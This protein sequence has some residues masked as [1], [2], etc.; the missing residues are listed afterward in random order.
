MENSINNRK[1]RSKP[2]GPSHTACTVA[3]TF[4]ILSLA[5]KYGMLTIMIIL[6]A[7]SLGQTG[8]VETAN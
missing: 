6:S 8:K 3:R 5:A 7:I 1:V 2:A 4:C